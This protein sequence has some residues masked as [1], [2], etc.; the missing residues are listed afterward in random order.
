LRRRL[1]ALVV[2]TL[3]LGTAT[4]RAAEIGLAAYHFD[5]MKGEAPRVPADLALEA[6]DY[7]AR[8]YFLVQRDGPVTDAWR[9]A[10][11]VSGAELY[12]YIESNAFLVG[13]DAAAQTKVRALSGAAWIGPFQPAY[14]ISPEIGLQA[15]LS[16]ER[17]RDPRLLLTVRVFRDLEGVAAEAAKL[18]AEVLDRT[19][20]GFSRRLLLH[21]D[22]ER[23]NDLARIPD[24]WWIEEKPEF[25]VMNNTTK[26]VVQSNASGATPVWDHG[27]RGEGQIAT[28]MD[29]GVD[30]NS[31]WFRDPEIGPPG[32]S[33][34]KIIDYSIYGGAAYDG[35]DVGHGSHVAGTI[36]GDQSVINAGNTNYNGMAYKAKLT[37]Q[38]IGADDWTACNLGMVSAPSSL[39]D[40]FTASYNLGAR[41]HSNSWG[42][43][44]NTYDSYCVD[45]DNAM[46]LHKDYLVCFAA[47][48]SGPDAST[49]GS[50][51]T[52][53]D[54]V[55]VGAT[56]Q[57]PSQETIASYSS[58]GPAADGRIKPTLTAPG[59][60][61]PTFITSVDNNIGNP[62]TATCQTASSPFQGTSMATPAVSGCALDVRQYYV[63]GFYPLG[64]TG[65]NPFIP[66]AALIKATLIASTK[67]MGTLDI[68]NSNEGWGRLLLDNALYFQGDTRELM[69][70]DSSA[71]LSTGQSW[72]KAFS[73]DSSS[74][75]LAISLVWTDYPGTS[76]GAVNLINNLD[77]TVTAP[78]GEQY[79]GNVLS[80]GQ[81]VTGGT[82]DSKNVE[83]GFRLN[84]P[85][86]GLWTVT[87]A[88]TSVPQGPQPF[89]LVMNGAFGGW[90]DDASS[91]TP[92]ET[93]LVEGP[94]LRAFPNPVEQGTSLHYA[95]PAGYSGPVRLEIL[96]VQGRVRRTLVDKGQ[97]PGDYRVTWEG[98]DQRGREMERGVYFAR[99]TAGGEVTRLKLLL[100]K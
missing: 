11:K 85:A 94:F 97:N 52:A 22:K 66:S 95:V 53:K 50:P 7:A 16:P 29:T 55:T 33:H 51:G 98:L 26:W 99:L 69:V 71:G 37:V 27:I 19:D 42:S 88:A 87:V 21:L 67:D 65:G 47:G 84:N 78:G 45:V 73:I 57:A 54:C 62:P 74:E 34:R 64:S 79:K 100:R 58:R 1:I 92:R 49:A 4:A 70:A 82:Y 68:P 93:R 90:P 56:Q 86:V 48:N 5:P 31:C 75:P 24:V 15:F 76:G 72:S 40:A 2:L 44:S 30:Y 83:E 8:G 60:E 14:K 96:D 46:W 91:G 89:A 28:L 23:L 80:G 17:L 9:E 41:V 59:G 13:L 6:R 25:R 10:L 81:S 20:D 12:G 18:G 77:L 3:V 35:C 39:T 32:P 61:D 43:T 36:C 38:D 63:D